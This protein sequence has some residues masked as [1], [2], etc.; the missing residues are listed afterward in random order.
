MCGI[1]AR[2]ALGP[3]NGSKAAKA[4]LESSLEAIRGQLDKSL[5][6]IAHR[7]PDA[8]GIW[9]SDD[10]GVGETFFPQFVVRRQC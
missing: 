5:D 6:A 3:S 8:K 9:V 1:S 2:V 4:S 7:G 10:G